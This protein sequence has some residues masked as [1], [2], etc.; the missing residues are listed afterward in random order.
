MA[1]QGHFGPWA[2]GF[3][4]LDG[5]ILYCSRASTTGLHVDGELRVG[6]NLLR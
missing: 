1:G 6:R 5:R 2:G 4:S 3:D